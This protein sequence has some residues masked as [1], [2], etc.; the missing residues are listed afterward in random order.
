MPAV[1]NKQRLFM[2]AELAHKR[3]GQPTKTKMSEEH[4][5]HFAKGKQK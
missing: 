2:R 4:L 1:S 3:K 5:R